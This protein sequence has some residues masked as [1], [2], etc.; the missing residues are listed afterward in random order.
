MLKLSGIQRPLL[1][2]T[3]VILLE[4]NIHMNRRDKIALLVAK[5]EIGLEKTF[6]K[7]NFPH[8]QQ[9]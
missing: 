9:I 1:S 2:A 8:N 3:G 5:T 4:E 6:R 7:R